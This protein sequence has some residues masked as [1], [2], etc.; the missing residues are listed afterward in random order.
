MGLQ[1]IERMVEVPYIQVVEKVV[2]VP[3][4]GETVQGTRST[5]VNNLGTQRQMGMAETV[6]VTEMGP[7]LPAERAPPVINAVAP[8]AAPMSYGAPAA[9]PMSYAAPAPA[10]YAAPAMTMAAPVTTMAAAPAMTMAA[11]ATYA[12]P[13]TTM[14]AAPAM[15]MAAP[16]TYAAPTTAFAA[17]TTAYPGDFAFG[18][19]QLPTTY[20]AV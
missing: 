2:E 17:P 15:T 6:E 12:A 19:G 14:A 20:R 8:A 18:G 10:T 9:A 16:A 11:P 3:S 13:M 4:V 1:T 5:V 7:D